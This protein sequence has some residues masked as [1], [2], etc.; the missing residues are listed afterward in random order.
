MNKKDILIMMSRGFWIIVVARPS[1]ASREIS[2]TLRREGPRE[3]YGY[4][5]VSMW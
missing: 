1:G 2:G 5:E 4:S 3:C